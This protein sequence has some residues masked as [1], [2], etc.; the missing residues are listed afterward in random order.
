MVP[1]L[2]NF[3]AEVTSLLLWA[4]SISLICST[5]HFLFFFFFNKHFYRLFYKENI[6]HYWATG[7]KQTLCTVAMGVRTQKAKNM[8]FFT[9]AC[10][11]SCKECLP[12]VS[13][14]SWWQCTILRGKQWEQEEGHQTGIREAD[15]RN[16]FYRRVMAALVQR[17]VPSL[18]HHIYKHSLH[19][20]IIPNILSSPYPSLRDPTYQ[21]E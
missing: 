3:E 4:E 2:L 1:M 9:L 16:T 10:P 15:F 21:N 14:F 12:S 19:T 8:H 18:E 7:P 13:F 20:W 17:A 6:F 5:D 11:W